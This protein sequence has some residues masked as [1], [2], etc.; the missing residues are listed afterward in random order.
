MRL[1]RHLE[2]GDSVCLPASGS[3]GLAL[4]RGGVILPI[5]CSRETNS[6]LVPCPNLLLTF[7]RVCF[8]VRVENRP[9]GRPYG[10]RPRAASCLWRCSAT[11]HVRATG[12]VASCAAGPVRVG[13][14]PIWPGGLGRQAT[15][16]RRFESSRYFLTSSIP[17]VAQRRRRGGHVLRSPGLQASV[18]VNCV[19]AAPPDST[20][21][22]PPGVVT[23][24]A[25]GEPAAPEVHIDPVAFTR[26]GGGDIFIF[27][28]AGQ[29]VGIGPLFF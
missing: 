10:Q 27:P 13:P 2:C 25:G 7:S 6:E 22:L 9:P 19:E 5:G 20:V 15:R 4:I 8:L 21:N 11:L 24:E 17:A 23:A 29:A 1:G 26:C 18:L 28:G 16:E 12:A 14:N 3:S